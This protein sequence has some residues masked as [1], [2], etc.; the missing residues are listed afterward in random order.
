MIFAGLVLEDAGA[1]VES[2][3]DSW[4]DKKDHKHLHNWYAYLR[5]SFKADP[6]GRRYLRS[7]VLRLKFE[8]GISCAMASAGIGLLWLAWMGLSFRIVLVNGMLC[9]VFV[10]WGVVEAI[11]THKTLAKNRANL[12][13]DIRII[14]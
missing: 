1:R 2:W 4:R 12:L 13:E 7:L 10:A 11:S 9:L 5:T 14:G 6:I 8:L 3:M